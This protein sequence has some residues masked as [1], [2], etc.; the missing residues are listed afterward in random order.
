MDIERIQ[1]YKDIAEYKAMKKN[2][3]TVLVSRIKFD[4]I[5]KRTKFYNR[6][7]TEKSFYM[8]TECHNYKYRTRED[9]FE[10][11]KQRPVIFKEKLLENDK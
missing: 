5:S 10:N 8:T 3:P 11:P 2:K 6:I 7:E 1:L 4:E 9:L